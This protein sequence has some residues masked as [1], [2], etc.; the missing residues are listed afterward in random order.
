MLIII[1]WIALIAVTIAWGITRRLRA[2]AAVRSALEKAGYRVLK[3]Q[4]RRLRTGPY[5]GE[6]SRSH[7]VFRVFVSDANGVERC[8][9]ARWGRKW[10]K[11]PDTLEFKWDDRNE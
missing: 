10:L 3:M 9:W 8:V 2:P 1:V 11:P 6:T 5:S 7:F 4:H